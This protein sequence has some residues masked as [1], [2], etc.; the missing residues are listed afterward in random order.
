MAFAIDWNKFRIPISRKADAILSP[1][2]IC[3]LIG[4]FFLVFTVCVNVLQRTSKTE[5]TQVSN[6]EIQRRSLDPLSIGSILMCMVFATGGV[7]GGHFN[8]AVTLTVHVA[9][10]KKMPLSKVIRYV[11]VQCM[12]GLI[13]AL[14]A[15]WVMSNTF[16]LSPSK[17][18]TA[19]DVMSVETFFATALCFVVLSCATS[20]QDANNQYFGLAIGFTVAAAAYGIGP[21]S[22]CAI[23]PAFSF[24]VMMTHFFHTG[25]GLAYIIVYFGTPLIGSFLAAVLFRQI[26]KA[27]LVEE[28]VTYGEIEEFK[29]DKSTLN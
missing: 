25:R 23:N 8:P 29:T 14:L 28:E 17:N 13:A 9:H 19:F 11:I 6:E 21:V 4:T 7:S 12:G 18:R 10:P 1:E 22:G 15:W 3:E 2:Y 26:R 20:K 27:E 16:T 5:A 24:G